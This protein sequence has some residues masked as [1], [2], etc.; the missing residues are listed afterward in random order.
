M[1]TYLI[2]LAALTSGAQFDL[3]HDHEIL[4]RGVTALVAPGGVPGVFSVRGNAF[5]VATGS[6]SRGRVPIV[7]ATSIEKGRVIAAS[8]GAFFSQRALENPSNSRFLGNLLAWLGQKPLAGMRVG[9]L[10]FNSLEAS[11]RKAGASTST[12]NVQNLSAM[13]DNCDVICTGVGPLENDPR[14]QVALIRFVKAGHGLLIESAAWG[15]AQ[16]NPGKDLLSDHPGNRMLFPFG[17][18]F[19]GETADEEFLPEPSDAPLFNSDS[20]LKA[21]KGG[22]LSIADRT[23]ATLTLERALSILPPTDQ[24][25]TRDIQNGAALESGGGVPTPANPVGLDKPFS[26]LK[27]WLEYR[28][29]QTLLPKDIKAH[30]SAAAFPGP[31]TGPTRVNRTITIDTSV[32]DWHGTGLYA[33]PGE[34]VDIKV[35][36][37]LGAA[38][39]KVRIGP[40]TDTL[41]A[42]EKWPRFPAISVEKP[43][44]YEEIQVASAFGGLIYIE[45]PNNCKAG[46]VEVVISNAVASAR[47]VQGETA[48]GNWNRE[49]ATT[50]A[51][52]AEIQGK[53]VTISVPTSSA[54]K[55]KDPK[56]L[57]A[58][59]DRMMKLCYTFYSAPI[60]LRPERYCPDVEIGGGYMHSGYPIMTHMDVADTFCDLAKLEQ[61]GTTWGFYHEMGHNFQESAWTWDGCGE[62]TNNFFSLYGSEKLNGETPETYSGAMTPKEVNQRLTKYLASGAHYR[63]WKDD[64]FLALVMFAEL[65]EQFGW[66]IFTR[67]FAEY[68]TLRPEEEPKTDI[69]KRDRWMVRFS[70]LVGK[71]LGPFFNAWGVPTSDAARASIANLPSWMPANWPGSK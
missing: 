18:C 10:G 62:V 67:L 19:T 20:A 70:K 37:G 69:E 24:G 33:A 35:P 52:W 8:H 17:I 27:A 50:L 2:S 40:H 65:R 28:I 4:T 48:I 30:P 60:R 13:V 26:R 11:L 9:L 7:V 42:L 46:P 31:V 6:Q 1:L 41:W 15:W 64:P 16:L 43:I 32:P 36:D 53:Y 3:A 39:L 22:G 71:N 23:T 14:S 61:K 51:P 25:L 29:L 34:V 68:R 44:N 58:F 5:V 47:Y 56:A 63:D 57:M 45:V 59:W 66:E 49:L 38:G 12:L 21:L 55:I 54:R